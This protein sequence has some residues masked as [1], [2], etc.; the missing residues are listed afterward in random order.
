MTLT[1]RE[2][3]WKYRKASYLVSQGKLKIVW[4][5]AQVDHLTS[6]VLTQNSVIEGLVRFCCLN[7]ILVV[8]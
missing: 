1:N 5:E 6:V 7:Y 2:L 4:L 3:T 8:T